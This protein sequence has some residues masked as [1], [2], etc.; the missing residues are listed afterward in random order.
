MEPKEGRGRLKSNSI[1]TRIFLEVYVS[2]PNGL[3]VGLIFKSLRKQIKDMI[4]IAV[5]QV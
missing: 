5:L 2:C 1:E 4:L 3:P